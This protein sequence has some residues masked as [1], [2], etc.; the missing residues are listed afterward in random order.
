MREITKMITLPISDEMMTF[1]LTK[2]D[3]FS[4]G[5]LLKLLSAAQGKAEGNLTLYDFLFSLEDAEFESVMRVCLAHAEE[6]L[7]AGFMPVYRDQCWGLPELE[8]ETRLCLKLTLEVVAFS[9]E[10]FFPG[11]GST[12]SPGEEASSRQSR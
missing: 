1:R 9:L 6:Q 5:R 11:S 7:P 8:Y 10:S 2:L 12:L 3:A 4:G